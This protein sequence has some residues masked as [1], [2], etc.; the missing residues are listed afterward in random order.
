MLFK[1]KQA[2]LHSLC[3]FLFFLCRNDLIYFYEDETSQG[4][5]GPDRW[6]GRYFDSLMVFMILCEEVNKWKKV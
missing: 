5:N 4:S 3:L 6:Y 1:N 2:I